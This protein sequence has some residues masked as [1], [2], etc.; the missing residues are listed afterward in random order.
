LNIWWGKIKPSRL[1]G[2]ESSI[3]FDRKREKGQI[4]EEKKGKALQRTFYST[5]KEYRGG[6]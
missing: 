2:G 5:G 6:S 4:R 1:E 3:I